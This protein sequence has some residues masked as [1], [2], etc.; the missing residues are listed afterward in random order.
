MN[1]N[2]F[3]TPVHD[4]SYI[5]GNEAITHFVD[6]ELQDLQ[7]VYNLLSQQGFRRSGNH[8]YQ[9]ACQTCKQCIPVRVPVNDFKPSK[10]QKR[11][12]KKNSDLTLNYNHNPDFKIYMPLYE[13][14]INQRHAHGDMF[15]PNLDQLCNFLSS[16]W[17]QTIA[18]EWF[19]EKKL[20]AVAFT[21]ILD[22]G[23]SAIYSIF[24]P[25]LASR[26]LGSY[27]I[28]QQIDIAK[29]SR[30]QYLYLGFWIKPCR[31]MSYK[32]NFRPIECYQNHQWVR[33]SKKST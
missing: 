15:P 32:G 7:S 20:V 12:F 24:D 9:P 4:C 14:Y 8:I 31:V 33:L 29:Q 21:D 30:K 22:D 28:L 3:S 26:S 17:C 16:R 6:P 11:C 19:L 10:S 2:L 18:L 25:D 23:Y 27:A 13:K 1:I 5:K